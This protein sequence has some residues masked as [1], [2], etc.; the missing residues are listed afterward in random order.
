MAGQLSSV[1][2]G[3]GGV[4]LPVVRIRLFEPPTECPEGFL[5]DTGRFRD[6]S[7]LDSGTQEVLDR[8]NRSWSRRR[9]G[10][11]RR[12]GHVR[13]G[14][15]GGQ[16]RSA[17]AA[18]PAATHL[19]SA[20]IAALADGSRV[21]AKIAT[22]PLTADRLRTARRGRLLLLDGEFTPALS[23]SGRHKRSGVQCSLLRSL[24][25]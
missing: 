18:R 9:Y 1:V 2:A 10:P 12:S 22:D 7:P 21:F 3:G 6:N 23:V 5:A 13:F 4:A 19:R 14:A 25:A 17:S 11:A 15:L 16:R 8:T 20:W 24:S